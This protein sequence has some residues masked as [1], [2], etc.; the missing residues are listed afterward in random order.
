[1]FSRDA[2]QNAYE[3]IGIHRGSGS[4]LVQVGSERLQ[5]Y[6]D[7]VLSIIATLLVVPFVSL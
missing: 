5:G 7:A 3:A 2:L 6:S 4:L 1:M